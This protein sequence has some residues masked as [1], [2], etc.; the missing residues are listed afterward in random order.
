[1]A[2]VPEKYY[3]ILK[4]WPEDS[5]K[6]AEEMIGKYG[7]PTES[8]PTRLIWDGNFPWKRTVVY[9][10]EIQHDFPIPHKDILVQ[11][12]DYHVPLEKYGALAQFDGSVTP[13]RTTGELASHCNSEAM[14]F[15][16]LNLANDIIVGR[17]SVE[18]ARNEFAKEMMAFLTK[19]PARFTE[20]LQF[21]V[22]EQATGDPDKTIIAGTMLDEALG[23]LRHLFGKPE[24]PGEEKAA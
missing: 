8:T 13:H 5:R 15:L 23:K 1:M 9:R 21:T 11:V 6:V 7:L 2:E 4:D 22:S 10:E 16:A 3:Q 19:K 18:D 20:R 12:I 14:N 24:R 17:R